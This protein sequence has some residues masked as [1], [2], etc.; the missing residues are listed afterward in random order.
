MLTR[1]DLFGLLGDDL[2]HFMFDN[3]ASTE[4]QMQ[5]L[6]GTG[7]LNPLYF[8]MNLYTG[9]Q[10]KSSA[11][12][13][14][15]SP[16]A[17]PYF[18]MLLLKARFVDPANTFA[19]FGFKESA[20]APTF[21]MTESHVGFMLQQTAFGPRLFLSTGDGAT[22]TPH[23]QIT[24]IEGW[25]PTNWHSFKIELTKFGIKPLPII[26]PYF[27]D[28]EYI[29]KGRLWA[30]VGQ[31]SNIMPQNKVH[32]LTAYIENSAGADKHLEISHIIYGERYAD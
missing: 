9:V 25:D 22:P 18:S 14:Y 3:F 16:F 8:S 24:Q 27:N 29:E 31:L 19:F 32:Y 4:M 17:N 13:W 12:F 1:D 26:I 6:T 30:N 10:A 20:L 11:R 7:Y 2:T 21:N 23:Q 15:N 28:I 5:E